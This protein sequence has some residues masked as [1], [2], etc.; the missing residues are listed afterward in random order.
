LLVTSVL[1]SGEQ[2]TFEELVEEVTEF[3]NYTSTYVWPT[4]NSAFFG[5]QDPNSTVESVGKIGEF[6]FFLLVRSHIFCRFW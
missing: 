1:V 6:V 5:S 4:S 2:L 3:L